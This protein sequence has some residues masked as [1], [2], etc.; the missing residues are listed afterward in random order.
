MTSRVLCDSSLAASLLVG[1][2]QALPSPRKV[3]AS[4]PTSLR[5]PP[6]AHPLLG[7]HSFARWSF[8]R[9]VS[10]TSVLLRSKNLTRYINL[11]HQPGVCRLIL[12]IPC[13]LDSCIVLF[14][15][16]RLDVGHRPCLLAT[17]D[18]NWASCLWG[19]PPSGLLPQV[20]M[21]SAPVP[22]TR[23]HQYGIRLC[24]PAT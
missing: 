13:L 8:S 7:C 19:C 4:A 2:A 12:F 3:T 24:L 16:Y 14:L 17:S 10:F 9:S 5:L 23:S 20:P 11:L 15:T 1:F 18:S 6:C 22:L 21:C